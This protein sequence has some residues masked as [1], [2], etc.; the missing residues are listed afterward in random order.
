MGGRRVVME[1]SVMWTA[2]IWFQVVTGCC[3]YGNEPSVFKGGEFRNRD[4]LK[5]DSVLLTQLVR[6]Y[7]KCKMLFGFRYFKR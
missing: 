2:Y 7:F 1:I 4:L 5:N 3:E 6:R